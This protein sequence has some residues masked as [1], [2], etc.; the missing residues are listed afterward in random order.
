MGLKTVHSSFFQKLC[1]I[2][3]FVFTFGFS[4]VDERV[5]KMGIPLGP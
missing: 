1:E 5:V 2:K 4:L 3:V